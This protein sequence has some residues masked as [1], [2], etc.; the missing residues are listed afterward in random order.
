MKQMKTMFPSI[1]I[2]GKEIKQ[3]YEDTVL[4]ATSTNVLAL[5]KPG[6]F[7]TEAIL[8]ELEHDWAYD[9]MKQAR[10]L[11]KPQL[12]DLTVQIRKPKFDMQPGLQESRVPS[13]PPGLDKSATCAGMSVRLPSFLQYDIENPR[14]AL[15][16]TGAGSAPETADQGMCQAA[17]EAPVS[18]EEEEVVMLSPLTK[19][20]DN[21]DNDEPLDGNQPKRAR[22]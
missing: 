5:S 2:A 19:R 21:S 10:K 17:V 16:G 4:R 12:L 18:G 8:N 22:R 15:Y 7:T 13:A 9:K 14:E 20:V 3:N 11:K 1:S 6:F